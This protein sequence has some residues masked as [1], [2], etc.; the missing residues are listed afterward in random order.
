MRSSLAGTARNH[1][2]RGRG[3]QEQPERRE[4]EEREVAQR[5]HALMVSPQP[6]GYPRAMKPRTESATSWTAMADSRSPAMRVSRTIPA[7]RMIFVMP[8]LKRSEK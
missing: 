8:T 4:Q 7:S 1:C 6:V 2:A 3:H 5:R